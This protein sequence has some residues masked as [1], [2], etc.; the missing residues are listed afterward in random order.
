V[1]EAVSQELGQSAFLR[2]HTAIPF[3]TTVEPTYELIRVRTAIKR[4]RHSTDFLAER[5]L[6][7]LVH[8]SD[9]GFV[10]HPIHTG[11]V[12]AATKQFVSA[13]CPLVVTSSAHASDIDNGILRVN[14]FEPSDLAKEVRRVAED[15]ELRV[16]L[17]EGMASEYNRLN[18]NEVATRYLELFEELTQ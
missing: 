13:R 6:L 9:L 11:S 14:S 17:T 2:I 15:S 3:S 1:I 7:D 4:G 18:M 16:R 10:F 12:S 8:A 5:D